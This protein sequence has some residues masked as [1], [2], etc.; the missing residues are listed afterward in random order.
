MKKIFNTKNNFLNK[1][2]F[3]EIKNVII[4]NDYFPWFFYNF[5]NFKNDKYFQFV[6]VFFADFKNNSNFSD[7]MRPIYKNLNAKAILRSK[8]N[9][10]TKTDKIIEHG[11]H[12]D[13]NV[14]NK[15]LNCKNALI[16]LNDNDGYTIFKDNKEKVYSK[17]NKL[18]I[19]NNKYLHSGTSCTNQKARF[20]ININYV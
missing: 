6:H 20:V 3:T 19:F 10:T 2:D 4:N 13:Q 15:P 5:V 1:K 11:Y 16:Y 12:T 7:L 18:L 8:V 9:L 17:S 14:N